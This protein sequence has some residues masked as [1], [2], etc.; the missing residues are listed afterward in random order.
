MFE[1]HAKLFFIPKK[2]SSW[3]F[4]K[5]REFLLAWQNFVFISYELVEGAVNYIYLLSNLFCIHSIQA[6]DFL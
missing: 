6:K 4:L 1:L 2:I 5:I 3:R